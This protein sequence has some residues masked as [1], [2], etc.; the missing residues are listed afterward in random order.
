LAVRAAK[1]RPASDPPAWKITGWPCAERRM[2]SGPL[3]EKNSPLW[4]SLCS[5][6]LSKNAPLAL[7]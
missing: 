6:V 4:F 1:S 2:F 5:F 3:T 7:S